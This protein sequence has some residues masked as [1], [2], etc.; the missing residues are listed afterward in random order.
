M[1][2]PSV[3]SY[4]SF[5]LF[6]GTGA[7]A[8]ATDQWETIHREMREALA[9]LSREYFVR[10]GAPPGP[11]DIAA[12]A[13][14]APPAPW[15]VVVG[16]TGGIEKHDS[17]ASG[18]VALKSRLE[19]HFDDSDG[20]RWLTYNNFWWRKAARDVVEITGKVRAAGGPPAGIK[21]P[22]IV[23]YGHSWGAGSISKFARAL[24]KDKLEISLAIYIDSFT[25]RNP[26]VPRNVRNVVNFY[27]RAGILYGLPMRGKSKV[28]PEDQ[29][30]TRVL[31]NYRIKPQAE[32]WG[33][34]WNLLQP[35]LYRQ[36]HRIAHDVRL[37]NY[38]LEIINLKLSLLQQAAQ[39]SPSDRKEGL[40]ERVVI[41]GASVSS[42]EKATSPGLL[43]ARHMGTPEDR[44]MVIAEGGAE[45]DRHLGYLDNIA[46]FRPSLIIAVDL[47]YHDFKAS[48]FLSESR[49]EYLRDYIQRLHATGAVVVIGGVP[50]QV[51]L[52]HEHV[53][54]YL[55]SLAPE[56][57]RL[58]LL[59]S[60]ALMN[61]LER[62]ELRVTHEGRTFGLTRE[63]VFADRVHLNKLG[64][65][66]LAN[67]ILERLREA[68]PEDEVVHRAGL[69][70]P[71]EAPEARP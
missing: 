42:S 43:L 58:I 16:F 53:N 9:E 7:L 18:V 17:H 2:F 3:F 69:P 4:L 25:L 51:L 68:F 40:F 64:S 22:L 20:V 46:K 37:E 65:A 41:L 34:S 66:Y 31:G 10:E 52:R 15:L 5:L 33:W 60:E 39:P 28:I 19:A 49:R 62:G 24:A 30:A 21:Q 12:S 1:R 48:L 38:L 61:R 57:P 44:I 59:D 45:S 35:L 14:E 26:R 36:H 56:F 11:Q 6:A 54:R 27:Q 47:F 29:E 63:D 71:L 13:G 8:G 70:L 55:E 50:P 23:V 67:H 32:F